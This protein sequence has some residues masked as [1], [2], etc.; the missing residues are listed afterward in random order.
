MP[1]QTKPLTWKPASS[2]TQ[3]WIRHMPSLFGE[4]QT[5]TAINRHNR[6]EVPYDA[7]VG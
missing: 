2:I 1:P 6:G 5:D 3:K 4:G 7:S